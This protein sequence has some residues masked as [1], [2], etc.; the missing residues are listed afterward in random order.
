[1]KK[2]LAVLIAVCLISVNCFAAFAADASDYGIPSFESKAAA[3]DDSTTGEEPT[4]YEEAMGWIENIRN[5]G[6]VTDEEILEAADNYYNDTTISEEVYAEIYRIVENGL[7]RTDEPTTDASTEDIIAEITAIINDDTLA[8]GD[9]VTKIVDLLRARPA[10]EVENILNE[11]NASGI[12]DDNTYAMISDAINGGGSEDNGDSPVSGIQDFIS[13]I[14]DMLGIGGGG[15]DTDPANPS[16]GSTNN[17]SSSTS[18]DSG[19]F[20][21]DN[22]KTGDYAIA[23]VAGIAVVAGLALVLTKIKKNDKND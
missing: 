15:D 22:A 7:H 5:E 18:S 14:L 6:A 20:E 23:S 3:G 13:G 17:N 11:L 21:G 12:I 4:V 10:E 1:M 9:K 19:N 2:F 8:I 16:G